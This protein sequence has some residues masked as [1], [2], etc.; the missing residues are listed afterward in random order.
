VAADRVWAPDA[1]GP[2]GPADAAQPRSP[3]PARSALAAVWSVTCP[4][5]VFGL[6]PPGVR[7]AAARPSGRDRCPR[8]WQWAPTHQA[9]CPQERSGGRLPAAP[10]ARQMVAHNNPY[11][12][13]VVATASRW[14]SPQA[15]QRPPSGQPTVG[16]SGS[17][18]AVI[19]PSPG[20]RRPGRGCDR[21][22]T[23]GPGREGR[24]RCGLLLIGAG[25]GHGRRG[26]RSAPG[27]W[28]GGAAPPPGA[29]QRLRR[30]PLACWWAAVQSSKICCT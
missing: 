5:L 20:R 9:A 17:G 22:A 6:S 12:R 16:P 28:R 25:V 7:L 14:R 1:G 10:Q 26:C 18:A 19:R 23:A 30:R 24:H 13:L 29:G 27:W 4:V 3:C 11:G 15:S 2:W 8:R 21:Q